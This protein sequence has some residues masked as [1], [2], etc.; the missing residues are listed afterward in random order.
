MKKSILLVTVLGILLMAAPVWGA[1][2]ITY[3]A[4]PVTLIT[5][6]T[7]YE[8][9]STYPWYIKES[10]TGIGVGDLKFS[11]DIGTANTS[12]LNN[13]NLAANPTGTGH[14]FGRWIQKE[15]INN[16]GIAWTSFE[17][18]LQV[19]LGTPSG[20]GDGLSFADGSNII[21]SFS[22]D[23]FGTYTRID[24]TRDYLNFTGGTVAP[25]ATVTFWFAITDNGENSPFWLRE[26]PN[27]RDVVGTPEP[28]TLLLLG[29]GLTGLAG[30][31]RRFEK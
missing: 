8:G 25:N 14:D 18:E 11:S 4:G 19:V 31:R 21:S 23:I 16:T 20:S 9:D 1:P 13:P 27:K 2:S 12:A 15:V 28:L 17:M 24:T 10:F 30:L 5:S 3:E 26:T 22:S 6:D 29:L 7:S